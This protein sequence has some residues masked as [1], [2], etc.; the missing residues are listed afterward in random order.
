MG[1]KALLGDDAV[2]RVLFDCDVV[3][4]GRAV[5]ELLGAGLIELPGFG[6]RVEQ[7]GVLRVEEPGGLLPIFVRHLRLGERV[8]RGLVGRDLHEVRRQADPG[9]PVGEKHSCAREAQRADVAGGHEEDL[10]AGAGEVVG[11][12]AVG[13]RPGDDPLAFVSQ[14]RDELA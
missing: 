6:D 14:F 1:G 3:A 8:G 10:V 13:R 2:D 5:D 9:Q 4:V 12:G 11:A 7:L